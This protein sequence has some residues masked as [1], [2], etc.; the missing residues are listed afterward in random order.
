LHRVPKLTKV[1]RYSTLWHV[2]VES[3]RDVPKLRRHPAQFLILGTAPASWSAF[4]ATPMPST[5]LATTELVSTELAATELRSA[6]PVE[7]RY[8]ALKGGGSHI[9]QVHQ[10]QI[11]VC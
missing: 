6:W 7:I 3:Q 4:F 1:I 8:L 2:T 5:A 10:R 9:G 11:Q